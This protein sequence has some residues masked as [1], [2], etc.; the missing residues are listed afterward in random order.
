MLIYLRKY[1]LYLD[2][3]SRASKGLKDGTCRDVDSLC[4]WAVSDVLRGVQR[5]FSETFFSSFT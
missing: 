4:F 3:F 1:F 5:K 2:I